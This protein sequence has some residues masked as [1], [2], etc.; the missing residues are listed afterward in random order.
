M[1]TQSYTK[2]AIKNNFRIFL[3]DFTQ[4]AN[5]I[6]KKQKTDKVAAIILASAI[7]TFGP[8]SRIINSKNQKTTTLLKSENIDS[9]IVDSNSNGNIRAM[10]SHDDFALEIKDFSQLNYLQLL[11]K[12]VGNKGFLKV[13][14]Q[15]NEQNYGGQVNLQKG[16]LISDLAFYFNL[17]EQ[18]ASAVKLFL[19]IDANGKII[20]AQ[21]AIFQLLPIHNE[22][23][24]NWLESLLKQNSLENLGLEKF[25]N[26]LDVKILDK[27]LWQ[28]KCSCSKQNTR[29]LLKLL[30][31]EDVEKILQ[32]QSKIEL[33]CQ[34][35]KKNYHFNK[36]DW[37][38]ENTEQTISCVE[39]FTGGGFASKIV[40]T[41]GASKYF[42]GGLVAYTNEIKAKLNIDTSK[43]VVNKET[44]LA[45]A[46]NGKK[47]FNSTFCVSFTGSAG[48]TAQ[49]GTKV[50]QVFIAINNK[51][52]E[53]NYKGT[54]KQ[55]IQKS[56]NFALNK[57]KKMVNFTL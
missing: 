30:S 55:I 46:K 23:D 12:T 5:D 39:S 57:L 44:A 25:E 20:K 32:K 31:N 29:N 40:S 1:N 10:F 28:Y 47:F 7:A 17:S 11:E 54:R 34:Y 2:T 53:L 13:V 24:I 52:W 49:E 48:P 19:E 56:I 42:K 9:L 21:S 37:K 4:V 26:L 22:E 16:N 6:I 45:M 51:V 14:S 38:L 50:G 41:P 3:S 15:I 36:I 27:K 33:I 8:L 18:V 43:G 35:C